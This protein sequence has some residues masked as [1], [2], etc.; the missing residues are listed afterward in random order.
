MYK[1][2][3]RPD[4]DNAVSVNYLCEEIMKEN[5]VF[6]QKMDSESDKVHNKPANVRRLQHHDQSG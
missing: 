1:S 3:N 4:Q 2:K 6:Y 5:I